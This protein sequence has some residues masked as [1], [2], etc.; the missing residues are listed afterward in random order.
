[1]DTDAIFGVGYS[2]GGWIGNRL[3]CIRGDVF[4]GFGTVAGGEPGSI[5]GCGGQVARI[6]INDNNDN[7]NQIAWSVPARDRQIAANGCTNTSMSVDPS[8]C[9]EYQGCDPG[10]PVVWCATSGQGHSR[11]DGLAAP[12][13]WNFFQSL[14]D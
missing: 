9:V 2:S 5:S 7:D 6:F 3:T 10:Y 14:M 4:R 13:F 11:Q 1:V 8:P 12:A